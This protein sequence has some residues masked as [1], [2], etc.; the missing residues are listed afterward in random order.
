M[1]AARLLILGGAGEAARLAGAAATRFGNRLDI[2]YSLAG[3]TR[4]PRQ[5]AGRIRTGG[6][7][8]AAGLARYLADQ[9]IGFVVDATHPFATRISAN[10]RIACESAGAPR[11]ILGR[12]PWKPVPGDNWIAVADEAEAASRLPAV[13][14]NAFLALGSGAISAFRDVA[15]VRFVVRSVDMPESPPIEGCTMVVGRGP[16]DA[17]A[18]QKL[19][20]E[21]GIDVVVSRNSGGAGAVGKITAARFL[22]IPV[23][24]IR[25][26]PGEP[27]D[28]VMD[29]EEVLTWIAKQ[30]VEP[31]RQ[32]DAG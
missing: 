17:R 16:F 22:G 2:V 13:G 20:T 29:I 3:R 32:V 30:L 18:E 19:L 1:N 8:G 11:L 21:Y 23:I 7:G 15:G 12:P 4:Q 9:R 14:R 26:P 10:A 6:F 25:R 24:M 28:R 31:G 5:P 27:G